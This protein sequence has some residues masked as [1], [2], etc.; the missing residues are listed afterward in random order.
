MSFLEDVCAS[1][2]ISYEDFKNKKESAGSRE[3]TQEY[4]PVED[5]PVV[6][7][8]VKERSFHRGDPRTKYCEFFGSTSWDVGE[9]GLTTSEIAGKIGVKSATTDSPGKMAVK[10][11]I[12]IIGAKPVGAHMK[13]VEK[14]CNGGSGLRGPFAVQIYNPKIVPDVRKCFDENTVPDSKKGRM[15]IGKTPYRQVAPFEVK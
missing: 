4:I 15:L 2:K 5:M 9:N 11:A 6:P 8:S 7:S 12:D 3:R 14:G 1:L 13:T 10:V